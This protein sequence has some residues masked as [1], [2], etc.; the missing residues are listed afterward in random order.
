M[1]SVLA[2]GLPKIIR[3]GWL[4]FHAEL[5]HW[6]LHVLENIP[7]PV[8]WDPVLGRAKA[9]RCRRIGKMKIRASYF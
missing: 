1:G 8:I 6:L 3:L 5:L 4:P 7:V 9:K 2:D